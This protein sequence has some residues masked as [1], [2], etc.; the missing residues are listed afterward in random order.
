[1]GGAAVS[2]ELGEEVEAGEEVDEVREGCFLGLGSDCSD[3]MDMKVN[4]GDTAMI[5]EENA[6]LKR[7]HVFL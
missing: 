3:M 1:M 2:D 7:K 4:S 5:C 6:D